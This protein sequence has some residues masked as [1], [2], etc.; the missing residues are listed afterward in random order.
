MFRCLGWGWRG[1]GIFEGV[2]WEGRR[3]G[4]SSDVVSVVAENLGR[5][6]LVGESGWRKQ[7][8]RIDGGGVHSWGVRVGKA[9]GA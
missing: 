6:L 7:L 3:E 4:S 9:A 1:R 2:G 5:R 8:I